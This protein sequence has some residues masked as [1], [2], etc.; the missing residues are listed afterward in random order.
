M[1]EKKKEKHNSAIFALAMVLISLF[2]AFA[3]MAI[4]ATK[5]FEED[6]NALFFC[7]STALECVNT[8][9]KCNND[10]E[11]YVNQPQIISTTIHTTGECS[12]CN[13]SL[14]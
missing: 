13:I 7:K 4:G 5:Q 3:G 14:E 8:L 11:A 9:E 10:F 6:K 1:V 12:K 2:I